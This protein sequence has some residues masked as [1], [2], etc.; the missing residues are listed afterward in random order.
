[1]YLFCE[2]AVI[3]SHSHHGIRSG[4]LFSSLCSLFQTF[5]TENG[6]NCQELSL[7]AVW[8]DKT[9]AA[10]QCKQRFFIL[11]WTHAWREEAG[12]VEF[13][14]VKGLIFCSSSVLLQGDLFCSLFK[15]KRDFQ[16]HLCP[17]Q[18]NRPHLLGWL[19]RWCF[20][21]FKITFMQHCR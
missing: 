5:S 4:C 3:V 13:N 1:M 14:R 19:C 20:K 12:G 16:W 8:L 7:Q 17:K 2:N 18:W 6:L 9:L 11:K 10:F 21:V 15:V